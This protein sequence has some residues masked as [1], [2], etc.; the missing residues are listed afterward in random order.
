MSRIDYRLPY[1][2]QRE[3]VTA[4]NIVATSVPVAA[5]AGLDILRRG[6]GRWP[7]ESSN[8]RDSGRDGYRG[9]SG[10]RGGHVFYRH[11][12]HRVHAVP[13]G[14][15]QRPDDRERRCKQ[16][17]DVWRERS[18]SCGLVGQDGVHVQRRV[19]GPGRGRVLGMPRG[20]VQIGDWACPVRR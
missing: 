17:P 8:Q 11:G 9:L 3:P 2:S 12:Q 10:L 16:L 6:G 1:P 13:G 18:V 14:Q 19:H 20:H 7:R 15:V 5:A 4:R